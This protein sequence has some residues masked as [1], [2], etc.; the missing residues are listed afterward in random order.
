MMDITIKDCLTAKVHLGHLAKHWNPYMSQ[1]IYMECNG[2]HIIDV[3][4]TISQLKLASSALYEIVKK[5]RKVLFVSTK[6]Q[7]KLYI[8]Q[9]AQELK[10]PYMTEKW[11]AGTL[12]NFITIRKLV[13]KNNL[14][15]KLIDSPNFKFLA[16]KERISRIRH[17]EA[18]DKKLSGIQSMVKLPGAIVVVDAHK[19]NIAVREANQLKIP[20]FALVDTNTNPSNINFPIPAN[21]DLQSSVALVMNVLKDSIQEGLKMYEDIKEHPELHKEEILEQK[22]EMQVRNRE[23]ETT[24]RQVSSSSVK[25]TKNDKVTNDKSVLKNAKGQ[26]K[27]AVSKTKNIDLSKKSMSQIRNVI[28]ETRNNNNNSNNSK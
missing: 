1:Y 22:K 16:K 14:A 2:M 18:L 7:T 3:N 4:K 28:K 12:T 27:P 23:R 8:E 15:T 6:K 10:M 13:K 24:K 20:V 19:E 25:P 11:F 5:G 21:A 17:K 9:I 26:S